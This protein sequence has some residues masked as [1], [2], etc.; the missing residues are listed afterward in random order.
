[1]VHIQPGAM[2]F[3]VFST[4]LISQYCGVSP[5]TIQ[6]VHHNAVLGRPKIIMCKFITSWFQY[7]HFN[8]LVD[9][10]V[11]MSVT[12]ERHT[13]H[14]YLKLTTRCHPT[15]FSLVIIWPGAPCFVQKAGEE[16]SAG[17][18]PMPL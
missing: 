18:K 17:L 2:D 8:V 6:D 3:N 12:Q 1:M 4:I 16:T 11:N 13:W 9:F 7:E 10:D 15:S 14:S 5:I